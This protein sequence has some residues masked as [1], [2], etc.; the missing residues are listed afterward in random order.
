MPCIGHRCGEHEPIVLYDGQRRYLAAIK[1]HE[2]CGTEGYEGL[3]PVRSLIVLLLD[4]VPSPEEV[5]RIQAQSNARELTLVDQQEQF[6]DCW[7]WVR[8]LP[9]AA[10]SELS[11][12]E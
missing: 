12:R 6:R 3:E 5:R 2:L 4:H 8:Y 11:A 7:Q 1:S 9:D 10:I